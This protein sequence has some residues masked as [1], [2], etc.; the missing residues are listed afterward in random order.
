[1]TTIVGPLARLREIELW[2]VSAMRNAT[3]PRSQVG[4]AGEQHPEVGSMRPTHQNTPST[5][6]RQGSAAR[7]SPAEPLS[8]VHAAALYQPVP[9]VGCDDDGYP[10]ED[11]ATVD[12]SDHNVV[13]GYIKYVVGDRYGDRDDVFVDIDSGLYFPA[14][15]LDPQRDEISTVS[16]MT[17]RF[18]Y[19]ALTTAAITSR[20][21]A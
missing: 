11:S 17:R 10:Y 2:Y 3:V 16:A 7:R 6:V 15:A 14:A 1:M 8:V 19:D 21:T 12:N 20:E 13:T 9:P 4:D 18:L 5:G